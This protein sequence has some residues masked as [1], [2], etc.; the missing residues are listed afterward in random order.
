MAVTATMRTV[1]IDSSGQGYIPWKDKNN[2]AAIRR[3]REIRK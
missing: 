3:K 2:C 1:K